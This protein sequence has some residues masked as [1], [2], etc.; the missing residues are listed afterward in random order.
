MA[1]PALRPTSP[2]HFHPIF[3][4][5]HQS[6]PHLR[7]GLSLW[8]VPPLRYP[9]TPFSPSLPSLFSFC[10]HFPKHTTRL[11][12]IASL[13]LPPPS[14]LTLPTV[15]PTSPIP[16]HSG[17]ACHCGRSRQIPLLTLPAPLPFW[18]PSSILCPY[19]GPACH[20]GR[21]HAHTLFCPPF[22]PPRH[23]VT[24]IYSMAHGAV[25]ET[26]PVAS[27]YRYIPNT[28]GRKCLR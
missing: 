14:P 23:L 25:T 4:P 17:P 8:Q 27:R 26:F 3:I 21:S 9:P 19:F 5:N 20:C 12:T 1:G 22:F 28:L 13:T 7:P 2:I 11:A 18:I 16:Q 10:F 24:S 15:I 6:F